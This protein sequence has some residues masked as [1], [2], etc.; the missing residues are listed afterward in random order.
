MSLQAHYVVDFVF[1]KRYC[2]LFLN[3]WSVCTV[4]KHINADINIVI[5][6]QMYK[7]LH[8]M[9]W[10]R[11]NVSSTVWNQPWV[12]WLGPHDVMSWNLGKPFQP[13]VTDNIKTRSAGTTRTAVSGH[14]GSFSNSIISHDKYPV[15]R[16]MHLLC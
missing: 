8:F 6:C 10:K 3:K 2:T 14:F 5:S 1:L 4:R 9:G 13:L 12:H 11:L 15:E 7:D 16:L